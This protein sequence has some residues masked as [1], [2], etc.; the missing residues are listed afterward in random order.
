MCLKYVALLLTCV[1]IICTIPN[2]ASAT[3][4]SSPKVSES[5]KAT[6]QTNSQLPP[7]RDDYGIYTDTLDFDN[8][9]TPILDTIQEHKLV[10]GLARTLGVDSLIYVKSDTDT[11]KF[12]LHELSHNLGAYHCSTTYCAMNTSSMDLDFCNSCKT[13]IY[14]GIANMHQG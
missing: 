13:T 14:N 10:N 6:E 2:T 5:K 9:D 4:L 8:P 12:I 1:I 3:D 7:A 11:Q